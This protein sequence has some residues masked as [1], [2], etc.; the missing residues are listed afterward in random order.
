VAG[1]GVPTRDSGVPAQSI[2]IALT[3]RVV[4]LA[5]TIWK[6]TRALNFPADFL[7][8]MDGAAVGAVAGL[9]FLGI[10]HEKD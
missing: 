2:Q 6:I 5:R 4:I 7:G 9:L 3:L 10:G 1:R 8:V